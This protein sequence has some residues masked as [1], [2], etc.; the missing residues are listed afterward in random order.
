MLWENASADHD[1]ILLASGS[2]VWITLEAARKLAEE[3][4]K[5]RVVSFPCWELFEKQ[6]DAYKASVLPDSGAKRIAVEA[7]SPTG[8]EKYVGLNGKIIGIDH[9]GASAPGAVLAE[10]FGITADNVYR[11]AQTLLG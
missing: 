1:L 9:F 5:V 10:K 2:E 3:G 8:W 11:Q 4:K 7:G 6:D